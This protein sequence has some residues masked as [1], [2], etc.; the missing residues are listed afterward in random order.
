[1]R[2]DQAIKAFKYLLATAVVGMVGVFVYRTDF[3]ELATYLSRLPQAFMWVMIVTF[4][5]YLSGTI[6]WW[7]CIDTPYKRGLITRMWIIRHVGEMLAIFNPT[8]VIAGDSLKTIY[9]GRSGIRQDKANASVVLSRIVLIVTGVLL[10][11]VSGIFFMID[12]VGLQQ[13]MQ[14]GIIAIVSILMIFATFRYFRLIRRIIARIKEVG[15]VAR[16]L[17]GEGGN[18]LRESFTTF[19][20]YVKTSKARV[21]W[22]LFFGALHW[23]LG[24]AEIYVILDALG[25]EVTVVDAVFFEMGVQF[26]KSLAF[27]IPG[28]IGVEEYANKIVLTSMKISAN[29]VWLILSVM[30]RARQLLWLAVAALLYVYLKRIMRPIYKEERQDVKGIKTES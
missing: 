12:L 18:Q 27:V 3:N 23:V 5:A 19:K 20:E 2:S 1:M 6:S 25:Q 24:A 17:D 30:R 14:G 11:I 16:F 10:M 13:V 8:N 4:F 9:L 26:L 7:F 29:E 22:A 28:Q 21:F 15:V